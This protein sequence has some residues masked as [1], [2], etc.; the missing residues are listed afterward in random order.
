MGDLYAE[1]NDLKNASLLFKEIIPFVM[2]FSREK[3]IFRDLLCLALLKKWD[4]MDKNRQNY[5]ELYPAFKDSASDEFIKSIF[6]SSSDFK[7]INA[8]ILGARPGFIPL[9]A[10]RGV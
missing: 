2:N 7:S 6:D 1:K 4:E 8:L 10:L 9:W 3:Y 5:I